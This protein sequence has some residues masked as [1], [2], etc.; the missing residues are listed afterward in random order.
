ME[1]LGFVMSVLQPSVYYHPSKDHRCCARGRLLVLRRHERVG[2]AFRQFGTEVRTKEVAKAGE[3]SINTG[4]EVNEDEARRARGA[5]ARMNYMFQDRPDLS[6]ATRV[7]SQ[8]LSRPREEIVLVIKRAIRCLKCY[9]RSRV[10][11]FRQGALR[12]DVPEIAHGGDIVCASGR[13]C[14]AA[15]GRQCLQRY[16]ASPRQW[17]RKTSGHEAALGPKRYRSLF[18]CFLQH[19][20]VSQRRRYAYTFGKSR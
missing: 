19:P 4:D 15:C 14:I 8:Y 7:M 10:E 2:V 16:A 5:I 11:C 1:N 17:S 9:P 20:A 18:N 13:T 6:T 12:D 3:E